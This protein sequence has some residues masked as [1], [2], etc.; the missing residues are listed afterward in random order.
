MKCIYLYYRTLL[1][2]GGHIFAA[3]VTVPY[4]NGVGIRIMVTLKTLDSSII[5]FLVLIFLHVNLSNRSEKM[6]IS[7]KLF[8]ALVRVNMALIVIDILGWVFN[9]L[10]GALNMILNKGFNL[11][12]YI[13]APIGPILWILYTYYHVFH[14]EKRIKKLKHFL[15]IPFAFN[16]AV[17]WLTLY[18]GWF[19]SVDIN[20][21]YHRGNYFWIH[22]A[23]CYALLGFSFFV[24]LENRAAL[25]KR[26]F[27]SLLLYFV[28]QI[29]GTTIQVFFYGVSYNW[30]GMMLS[31]LIIYFNIQERSLCTDYLTG[32]YNRLQLDTYMK[33]KIK[34]SSEGKSFSAILIDLDRFKQINDKFGHSVG[35]EALQ[36][37]VKVI[38]KSI[39]NNDFVARFGGDEFLIVMDIDNHERLEE[40]VKRIKENVKK[41]NKDC[42]R[43]YELGFSMGYDVYNKSKAEAD[44]FFKH[45][46]RLMYNNKKCDREI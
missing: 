43:P 37:A 38:K 24:I 5:S 18:T 41:F 12:L 26:Y 39:R 20:N 16:A 8:I 7:Y 17:S 25:E 11:L 32:V 10:P 40:A 30:S 22:V 15:L 6:F 21:I 13:M 44:A 29:T 19:F 28:P 34:N 27:Y 46:D 3:M 1:K 31:L 45:I 9:G 42:S 36:D 33:L 2:I 4:E 23:L 14:D 35:D